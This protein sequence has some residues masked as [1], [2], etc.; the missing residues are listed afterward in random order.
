[1]SFDKEWEVEASALKSYMKMHYLKNHI[2][3]YMRH[4]EQSIIEYGTWL[5]KEK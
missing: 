5:T 4:I 2:R 1:M 3:L